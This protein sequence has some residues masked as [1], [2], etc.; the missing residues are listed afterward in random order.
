MIEIFVRHC[1]FS[2]ASQGKVRPSYFSRKSCYE[3]LLDTIDGKSVN[4]T[5]F[6][7]TF[8][9]SKDKHFIL[10][11]TDYPVIEI[12]EGR[13]AGS[14]LK[15]VEHVIKC[16]F[17]PDTVVY[18]LE[19]DYLH[20]PGWTQVLQEGLSLPHIDYVSLFDHR[21]KYSLSMYQGIKSEIF[22]TKSCHWRTTPSTTNTY[23]MYFKTLK[24]HSAV[25]KEFSLGRKITQDHEKFLKLARRGA[26]LIS[27][28]PGYCTHMESAFLSPCIDWE[29]ISN[30]AIVDPTK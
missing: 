8:F 7:D 15:M 27:P 20:R 19:D 13:E 11:Q 22:Y 1:H 23:A 28:I 2:S 14:F 16:S 3:N 9:P 26:K 10:E 21:D 30:L 18:F 29:K 17:S 6:L 4:V 5:F 12:K 24:K 25:H